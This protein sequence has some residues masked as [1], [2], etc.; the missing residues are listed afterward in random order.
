MLDDRTAVRTDVD[1]RNFR[2]WTN[3]SNRFGWQ[4]YTG[5]PPGSADVSGL[6]APAR[7]DDLSGVA[8]A[9]IGV[10]TLDL[11]CDEDRAYAARLDDAGVGCHLDVVPGAFHGFD[12][13]LP[14]AGVSRAFRTAQVEALRAALL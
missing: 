2:L 11:F 12:S 4:A 13:V 1:E 3:K 5:M 7:H 9:W 10:G 14:K 8:P 6:A